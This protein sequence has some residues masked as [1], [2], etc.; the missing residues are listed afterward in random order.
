MTRDITYGGRV[1][2]TGGA[3]FIGSHTYV[4]LTQAGYTVSILDNFENAR[5]DI[6]DKLEQ[7][8][9]KPTQVFECDIRSADAV[10]RVFETGTFDAVV[11]FAAL[12][13][14]PESQANPFGYFETNCVGLFNIVSAMKSR[15]VHKLVFS[16]SAA[17]YGDPPVMPIQEN[18]PHAPQSVYARTKCIGEDF[19]NSL[20]D[21]D[22]SLSIGILRYFNPVGAHP[23]GLIG[24]APSQPPTNLVPVVAKVAKGEMPKLKIFGGDYPTKDGTGV[25]DY[26]HVQ[27]LARGHVLSL[28]ALLHDG[29]NHCVNLGTGK[30][31]S[32]LDVVKAY[33]TASGR[34]IPYEI[35]ERRPGDPAVSCAAIDEARN[36][37]E[38]EAQLGLKDMCAGNWHF[39]KEAV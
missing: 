11:H 6:P 2:L 32:V 35:V 29:K 23:S 13:S 34:A 24:E 27:D 39:A 20:A 31:Y 14:V 28:N 37:L 4:E 19:L 30:G 7:I 38:F 17:V 8:T 5:R 26:I 25:R 18:A 33:E 1:L 3:G 22:N 9:G 21:A 36:V 16:S 12:K 15:G 10:N